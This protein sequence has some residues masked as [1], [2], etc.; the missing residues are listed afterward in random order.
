[1]MFLPIGNIIYSS[2]FPRKFFLFLAHLWVV[3]QDIQD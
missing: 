3:Q 1:L 2:V